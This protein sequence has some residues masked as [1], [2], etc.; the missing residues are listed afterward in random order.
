MLKK[1]TILT[2]SIIILI[3]K[4]RKFSLNKII[5]IFNCYLKY[6]FK[7]T[8]SGK[9]PIIITFEMWNECNESCLFCRDKDGNIFDLNPDGKNIP[10]QKGKL[11]LN[12]Y[13][14]IVEQVK[15]YASI[16]IPYVNGE[17]LMYKQIYE[18]IEFATQRKLATLIASNGIILS[19]KNSIKLLDSGLDFLKIHI[20]GFTNEIHNIE[21]RVGDV[22]KIKK[23][24]ETFS[25]LN[26]NGNYNCMIMLDYILYRHNAFQVSYAKNFSDENGIIFNTRP[27][28][29]KGLENEPPQVKSPPPIDLQCDFLWKALTINWDGSILPCCEY[30]VWSGE[31]PYHKFTNDM[32]IRKL[33]N[34]EQAKSM[35]LSHIEK[36]RRD[37]AICSGCYR[38]G[39]AFKF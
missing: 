31:S 29:P 34:G 17:P 26:S 9:T 27:G 39:V 36:G 11:D 28:N 8:K 23:N 4:K 6:I 15:D 25:K 32:N 30:S 5:N 19:K 1:Y 2:V 18:A 22:E 37:I 24:I 20:S 14:E 10:I 21:H 33:W 13:K 12:T 3:I 35:R 16:I 7:S 38:T